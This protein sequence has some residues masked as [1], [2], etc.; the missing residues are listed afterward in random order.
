[1]S[2]YQWT[3]DLLNDPRNFKEIEATI[4]SNCKNFLKEVIAIHY[5]R[6]KPLV[7]YTE[8]RRIRFF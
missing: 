8:Y 4:E 1:M 3:Y 6:V 2:S 7:R 5:R